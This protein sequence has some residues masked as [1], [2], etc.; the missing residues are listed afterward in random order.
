MTIKIRSI[1]LA[2]ILTFY[3]IF[4]APPVFAEVGDTIWIFTPVESLTSYPA[5]DTNGT[6]YVGVTKDE[7]GYIPD[8]KYYLYAINPDGTQKWVS[9]SMPGPGSE[10][11]TIPQPAIGN[12]GTIYIGTPGYKLYAYNTD[13]TSKWEYD[14]R[15]NDNIYGS[16]ESSL[17]IAKDGTIY[18]SVWANNDLYLYAINKDGTKKWS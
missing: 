12:E 5:I 9:P 14:F 16:I 17:A 15:A 3:I 1:I 13:G 7:G 4:T 18:V 6:I 8:Y 10:S 11:L 2:V